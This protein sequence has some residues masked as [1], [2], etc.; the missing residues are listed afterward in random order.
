[1]RLCGR[2]KKTISFREIFFGGE[3]KAPAPSG[4]CLGSLDPSLRLHTD[5][6]V[7]W[8][9]GGGQAQNRSLP[10]VSPSPAREALSPTYHPSPP[11]LHP[12]TGRDPVSA[13]L[14]VMPPGGTRK[15]WAE[16]GRQ[17]GNWTILRDL[18]SASRDQIEVPKESKRCFY[19]RAREWAGWAG[20]Q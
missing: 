16:F 5:H 19:V 11:T 10:L 17:G 4:P 3:Q 18:E 2:R 7:T 9:G 8:S 14:Q 1:M 12:G 6:G 13:S 20:V 15:G